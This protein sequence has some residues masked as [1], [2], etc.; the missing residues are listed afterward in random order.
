[1]KPDPLAKDLVKFASK[2]HKEVVDDEIELDNRPTIEEIVFNIRQKIKEE[3]KRIFRWKP[4]PEPPKTPQTPRKLKPVPPPPIPST[5]HLT[6]RPKAQIITNESMRAA[7]NQTPN[8]WSDGELFS[9]TFPTSR[10]APRLNQRKRRTGRRR[11]S[12]QDSGTTDSQISN[13]SS[14][15]VGSEREMSDAAV[16]HGPEEVQRLQYQVV[17]HTD[18]PKP[19]PRLPFA[20]YSKSDI[21]RPKSIPK[22]N[23]NA[24]P[25]P[26]IEKLFQE[27]KKVIKNARPDPPVPT[28]ALRSS[29]DKSYKASAE[30]RHESSKSSQY[31]AGSG[32]ESSRSYQDS[33]ESCHESYKSYQDSTESRDDSYQESYGSRQTCSS[34]R[35]ST[36]EIREPTLPKRARR[37]AKS[38]SAKQKASMARLQPNTQQK[39]VVHEPSFPVTQPPVV[40]SPPPPEKPKPKLRLVNIPVPEKPVRETKPDPFD[41]QTSDSEEEQVREEPVHSRPLLITQE[42]LKLYNPMDVPRIH[43]RFE[44]Q[45]MPLK[46]AIKPKQITPARKLQIK[47]RQILSEC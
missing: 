9:A 39:P 10:S 19:K 17:E 3:K 30:S 2:K 14:D 38:K 6:P 4:K 37:K 8:D 47:R 18:D 44:G 1:M 40:R 43:I 22:R 33:T 5:S 15:Y 46:V 27:H 45:S 26:D 29:S 42:S 7:K 11:K 16:Q 21:P 23:P 25:N 35:S 28:T 34:A 31:S 24:T 41:Q 36:A 12:L 20:V 32:Q 13:A